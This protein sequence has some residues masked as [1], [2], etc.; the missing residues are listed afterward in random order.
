V[1]N[2]P[3]GSKLP[4]FGFS[5]PSQPKK[6]SPLSQSFS[7]DDKG[8]ST[9]PK[10]PTASLFQ[11][12][13][14]QSP[15]APLPKPAK[16]K[17][18]ILEQL[19]REVVMDA[20]RGLI[21]QF[22]E[23]HARQTVMGVYDE[24]YMESI[25]ELADTF[26]RETLSYRF[27]KR[28]REICWRRRLARQGRERRKRAKKDQS[29]RELKRKLAAEKDAVDD[30][31]KSTRSTVHL[32]AR[33][34]ADPQDNAQIPLG[35]D[36]EAMASN[37]HGNKRLKSLDNIDLET[38]KRKQ[39]AATPRSNFLGFSMLGSQNRPA[40]TST[41]SR[42]NY[43]RLK[44]MGINP[45]GDTNTSQARKRL[46]EDSEEAQ[47]EAQPP[48][49]KSQ[50]PPSAIE[51]RPSGFARPS[52]PDSGVTSSLSGTIA[53]TV[54]LS[55]ARRDD[56][57]LFAR[58][59]AARQAM[60][61]SSTWYKSEIQ[62]DGARRKEEAARSLTSPSMERARELARLR[63]TGLSAA[64]PDVPA[65]RL[66]ES[67]F[68]PRAQYNR[69]IE[70]ARQKIE[71]RSRSP[72]R[73][74]TPEA[75]QS[76]SR[77]AS[78][79]LM[80][81]SAAATTKISSLPAQLDGKDTQAT[82]SMAHFAALHKAHEDSAWQY[83]PTFFAE[84]VDPAVSEPDV[85]G[86]ANGLES[87]AQNAI[88]EYVDLG[89][90]DE[91]E[92]QQHIQRSDRSTFEIDDMVDTEAFANDDDDDENEDGEEAD[93]ESEEFVG[94]YAQNPEDFEDDEVYDEDEEEGDE[95]E[96]LEDFDE[97]YEDEEE[98]EGSDMSANNASNNIKA[99]TGTAEDAFE[100]SD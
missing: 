38:P 9:T 86:H 87:L 27:G 72:S 81:L 96:D 82:D 66:R 30:F 49:K 25:R 95:E 15:V 92:D 63:S 1:T 99:G 90:D 18:E 78:Q 73:I 53:G 36:T 57:E 71:S 65:Y 14:S 64:S 94:G 42:S 51:A 3:F 10:A 58:A 47:A 12:S 31:L 11:P 8:E 62:K 17:D 59:R 56:E 20:D 19:A 33:L 48:N 37:S 70:I 85:D 23:Y 43:F 69:A 84:S 89:S 40:I 88:N 61:D 55:K 39:S 100:L 35:E 98:E 75:S 32:E 54:S 13:V 83:E 5:Q 29:A 52:A 46:R 74:S 6:P 7:L 2:T 68:V 77:S 4:Q 91:T 60:A 50:T 45:E 16:S 67:R 97:E 41:P 21:R 76:P 93:D 44:A 26:R 24:L 34:Q 80:A 22:V 28:W 79:G